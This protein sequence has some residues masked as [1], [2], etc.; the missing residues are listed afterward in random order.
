MKQYT[1]VKPLSSGTM[2]QATD[3]VERLNETLQSRYQ[4]DCEDIQLIVWMSD[5]HLHTEEGYESFGG[6]N[7]YKERVDTRRQLR[8]ALHE[9][10]ALKIT[11]SLLIFGGDMVDQQ[12]PEE[13]QTFS[14][15]FGESGLN[16]PS[17]PLFGNHE[18]SNPPIRAGIQQIWGEIKREG[19]PDL[20]DPDE[21]YY[22]FDHLGFKFLVLDTLQA[23]SYRMSVRQRSWLENQL[24][25]LEQSPQPA[26]VLCHRHQ[27]PVGNWVDGAIFEDHEVWGMMNRCPH[28]LGFFSGHVHYPQL[29]QL[30]R[31]LYC[32]FPSVAYGIGASTG[33][34]GIVIKEGKVEDV[35]YKE[36][37]GESFDWS[38]GISHFQKGDHHIMQ[39]ERFED[40][41][42]CTPFRWHFREFREDRD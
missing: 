8:L 37:F 32:T 39:A 7:Y 11:P 21:L 1:I 10:A 13:L 15:I 18:N 35:F 33:W 17:I 36:L 24:H 29:W 16:I 20:D 23:I 40:H 2:I 12:R 3:S 27:L 26:I 4:T 34:G 6:F 31:K 22:S 28:I 9:V 30:H 5:I 19:W 42:L 41:R 14:R 25:A 38:A